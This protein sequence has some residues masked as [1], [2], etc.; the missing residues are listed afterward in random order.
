MI[1]M[2]GIDQTYLRAAGSLGWA[3][4]LHWVRNAPPATQGDVFHRR[5][6]LLLPPRRT[7][8][9]ATLQ[10]SGGDHRQQQ[11]GV[12][13]EPDRGPPYFW[14]STGQRR[15]TGAVRTDRLH[16]VAKSF[17]VRGI[18]VEQPGDI[19][20]ALQQALAADGPSSSMS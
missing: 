19:A 14:Q 1:E 20:A 9:G 17:G 5:R 6:R 7:G 18:R 2:N 13:P 4:P 10:H 12:R 11:F 15:G 16:R 3:F 8:I